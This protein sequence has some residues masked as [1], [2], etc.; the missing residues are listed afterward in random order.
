M[1][2]FAFVGYTK[3]V[4]NGLFLSFLSFCYFFSLSF[5]TLNQY[6]KVSFINRSAHTVWFVKIHERQEAGQPLLTI[7]I[8]QLQKANN[9][10][11]GS[12]NSDPP[13]LFKGGE[14]N[15]AYLPQKGGF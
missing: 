3:E 6:C 1:F 8:S 15:F 5:D 4:M 9:F 7:T 11:V 10:S 12:H 14:V 2:K 13:P